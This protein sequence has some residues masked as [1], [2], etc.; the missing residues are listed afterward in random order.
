[1]SNHYDVLIAGGGMVGATLACA[2]GRSSLK[3]GVLEAQASRPRRLEHDLRVSAIT[4]ASQTVFEN[5][6]AWQS[7]CAQRV[8]PVEA[9]RVWEGGSALR[10]DSADIGEP[11]LAWIIENS[12][13]VAALDETMQGLANVERLSAARVDTVQIDERHVSVGLEDGRRCTASLLV[14]AD[15]ADSHV[16]RE[17]AIRWSR[18]DL[19]QLAIVAMVQ[20]GYAHACTAYQHFL[21]TGPLAFLPLSDPHRV[22]IVWSAENAR[23]AELMALDD[24]AFNDELQLAFGDLLGR[25]QLVSPRA[26][27]PLALGFA[28]DYSQHRIAL[29]GDAAHTV[30]PLAGQGVNLGIL[31]AATLAET[32]LEAADRKRD[33]GV[34]SLLRRYERARKGADVSMQVV[35]GGFR[36]LFGS[37]FPGARA[38]RDAGLNITERLPPLK[39]FF[40]RRA[41]GLAGELPRLAQRGQG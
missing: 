10:F 26:A 28:H 31:D 22:S 3:V 14:G 39:N 9:M 23:A 36:Y 30:H 6:G 34:H 20:T 25:V 27:I 5:L 16:R 7:M 2:L 40:V 35:T 37:N 19:G 15:G 32:L 29:I 13:I 4:L 8:S 38:L 17:A 41:S 1:M 18:H 21:P 24:S 33:I 11:R 12:V